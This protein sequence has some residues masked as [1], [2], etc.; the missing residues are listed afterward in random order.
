MASHDYKKFLRF[1]LVGGLNT[2]VDIGS[3]FVG[4]TIFGLPVVAANTISTSIALLVG[5]RVHSRFT[6]RATESRGIVAYVGITLVGLWG[7]QNAVIYG[8][9]AA[10]HQVAPELSAAQ[11]STWLLLVAKVLAIGAST[12]W[13]YLLYSR[14]VF[15]PK[16]SA[17]TRS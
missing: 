7:L 15:R 12:I 8:F 16:Q 10:V 1:I 6:F 13:N 17:A 9:L 3:L 11:K 5:Y 14:V 4:H 2:V